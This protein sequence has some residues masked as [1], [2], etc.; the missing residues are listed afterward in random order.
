MKEA[1]KPVTMV[2]KPE[3]DIALAA[4]RRIFQGMPEA[5]RLATTML[6]KRAKPQ[7]FPK[8]LQDIW[9]EELL[10]ASLREVIKNR[11]NGL[12]EN[13]GWH[14]PEDEEDICGEVFRSVWKA[15]QNFDPNRD[16]SLL[17]YLNHFLEGKTRDF[18]IKSITI[19]SHEKPEPDWTDTDGSN[20]EDELKE[21]LLE[22][23][24]DE[25]PSPEELAV[26]RDLKD[27]LVKVAA[28][29]RRCSPEQ[30]TRFLENPGEFNK[31]QAYRSRHRL[32]TAWGALNEVEQ[33]AITASATKTADNGGSDLICHRCYQQ[34]DFHSTILAFNTL[35]VLWQC[36]N[37]KCRS[38]VPVNS[39]ERDIVFK[40]KQEGER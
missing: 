39:D 11:V 28:S 36:P 10:A 29:R 22:S 7:D 23:I 9:F 18:A 19:R 16:T 25:R 27:K 17:G 20:E 14:L 32:Q 12:L 33:K 21:P 13:K 1:V 15:V 37:C 40:P 31:V 6:L 4:V 30:I 24:R 38:I 34:L 35:Y 8:M 26:T 2:P 3:S 5:D